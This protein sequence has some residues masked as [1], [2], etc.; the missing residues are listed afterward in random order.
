VANA[1]ARLVENVFTRIDFVPKI[2]GDRLRDFVRPR[3][4]T[5]DHKCLHRD[6]LVGALEGVHIEPGLF[7]VLV[8]AVLAH[9][10][11]PPAFDCAQI[12]ELGDLPISERH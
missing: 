11:S 12:Y 1:I 4:Q 7:P 3:V 2:L 5:V 10:L 6:G 9:L 8:F